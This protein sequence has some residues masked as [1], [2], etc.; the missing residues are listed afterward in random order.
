MQRQPENSKRSET[1]AAVGP[2]RV[3]SPEVRTAC[4]RHDLADPRLVI[5]AAARRL[6]GRSAREQSRK[7]SAEPSGLR[8]VAGGEDEAGDSIDETSRGHVG[9]SRAVRDVAG[10]DKNR[11]LVSGAE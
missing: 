2:R 9:S 6:Q 5:Q 8:L 4:A 11:V 3:E 10:A 7:F 1:D